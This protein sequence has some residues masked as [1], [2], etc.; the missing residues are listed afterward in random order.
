[1]PP[2]VS[3]GLELQVG[4]TTNGGPLL[5]RR[6]Q[7]KLSAALRTPFMHSRLSPSFHK[8]RAQ[9]RPRAPLHSLI[10]L[11][12][13]GLSFP[14]AASEF[15]KGGFNHEVISMFVA[16]IGQCATKLDVP[17]GTF[18]KNAPSSRKGAMGVRRGRRCVVK[19]RGNIDSKDGGGC[20]PVRNWNNEKARRFWLRASRTR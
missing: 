8:R 5:R 9:D 3:T 17:T 16:L 1:M 2:V 6:M 10:R 11:A 13:I 15:R 20:L 19:P 14:I 7:P 12:L 18:R 4:R